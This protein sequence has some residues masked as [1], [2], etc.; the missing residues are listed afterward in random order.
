MLFTTKGAPFSV[1]VY[2]AGALAP[3]TNVVIAD[4]LTSTVIIEDLT[5]ED[6]QLQTK[7][8]R[9]YVPT[10]FRNLPLAPGVFDFQKAT[11]PEVEPD[12]RVGLV[13][14]VRYADSIAGIA[15]SRDPERS[16]AS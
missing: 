10:S 12:W 4:D 13:T 8:F 6:N 16:G 9:L 14:N 5:N 7:P 11:E 15:A 1:S 3:A 2:H